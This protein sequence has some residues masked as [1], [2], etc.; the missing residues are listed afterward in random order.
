MQTQIDQ[1]FKSQEPNIKA[2]NEDK[3]KIAIDTLVKLGK[4]I[5]EEETQIY[6]ITKLLQTYKKVCTAIYM[7][8]CLSR[9]LIQLI[10]KFSSETFSKQFLDTFLQMFYSES[11]DELKKNIFLYVAELSKYQETIPQKL[12][13]Q[14]KTI[15]TIKEPLKSVILENLPSILSFP[16]TKKIN[17]LPIASYFAAQIALV[18]SPKNTPKSTI[19]AFRYLFTYYRQENVKNCEIVETELIKAFTKALK[20]YSHQM[21][22]KLFVQM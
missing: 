10:S 3:R 18:K 1:T 2:S 17:Q 15:N 20:I 11:N 7:K 22:I 16:E 9:V 14:M 6:F 12:V 8:I 4:Q 13:D 21:D 19:I 5:K